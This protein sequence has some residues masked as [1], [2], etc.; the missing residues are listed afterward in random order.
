[1]R[2]DQKVRMV[3]DT[4]RAAHSAVLTLIDEMKVYTGTMAAD[5]VMNQLQGLELRTDV[6]RNYRA[7]L[8]RSKW[9]V[10]L[11][12]GIS[13]V[14]TGETTWHEWIE[15][16]ATTATWMKANQPEEYDNMRGFLDF[17]VKNLVQLHL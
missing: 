15:S 14:G 4:T 1:M 3:D 12:G 6:K 9:L 11:N 10:Y 2:T 17:V 13:R 8:E 16:I 5:V 7:F